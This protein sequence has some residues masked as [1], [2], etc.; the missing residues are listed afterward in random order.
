MTETIQSEGTTP[1]ERYLAR[2]AEKSFLN[3]WSYPNLF[4]D[5]LSTTGA[6][7]KELCDLLVVCGDDIIVFSDK[8][9]AWQD[10]KPANIAWA[11]WA[12]RALGASTKQVRGAQRW[13]KAHPDRIFLDRGCTQR[14][15]INLPPLERMRLHGVVV[16]LGAGSAC[17]RYFKGGTGSLA[18]RPSI[19]G[20][21]HWTPASEQFAPFFVGDLCKNGPYVHVFDDATLDVVMNELDTIADFAGYLAKKEALIRSGRLSEAHGEEDLVAY[22]SVRMNENEE[23]DFT[24]PD[25]QPW[26]PNDSMSVDAGHYSEFIRSKEYANRKDANEPSYLW[27]R[28]ITQFTS[29][30][31]AGTTINVYGPALTL[32]ENEEGV[33]YMALENRFRRRMHGVAIL[34]ALQMGQKGDRFCRAMLPAPTSLDNETGFFFL[35]IAHP[36][37][38]KDY[39]EYRKFR[40]VHLEGYGLGFLQ[41]NRHLKRI[42]GIATEPPQRGKGGSEDLLLIEPGEWTQELDERANDMTRDLNIM[43][44][45]TLQ[46]RRFRG[47]EF[48]RENAVIDDIQV[49]HTA[50]FHASKSG[51]RR[52][53]RLRHK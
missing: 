14:F 31:L 28:L 24:R 5:Q 47:S 4:R 25:G 16:A 15:P 50:S 41:R 22:Y 35:T 18:I 37:D 32:S 29:N 3:L 53:R 43:Q 48:E 12:R 38:I 42:I 45:K 10:D 34:G 36:K 13:L 9:I 8:T 19:V 7:G 51:K 11:R 30:M 21:A 40:V 44:E 39:D 52:R 17:Q 26:Q 33:R 27:D 23:H 49:P 1:S 20:D 6:E 46:P 2:L